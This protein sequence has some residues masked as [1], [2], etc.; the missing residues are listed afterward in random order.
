MVS[1]NRVKYVINTISL[2]IDLRIQ[3]KNRHGLHQYIL[4]AVVTM[5]KSKPWVK[6]SVSKNVD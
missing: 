1:R 5:L 2:K 3:T 6:L 4:Y